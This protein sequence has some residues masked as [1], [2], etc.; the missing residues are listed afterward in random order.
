MD[1]DGEAVYAGRR[2]CCQ[3][4]VGDSLNSER[5]CGYCD[6]ANRISLIVNERLNPECG[7]RKN[8]TLAIDAG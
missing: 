7:C 8:F 6:S 2:L 4:G 1:A 3:H 5:L